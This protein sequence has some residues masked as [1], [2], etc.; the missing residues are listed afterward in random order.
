MGC[1]TDVGTL[2]PSYD[3]FCPS[4]LEPFFKKYMKVFVEITLGA[5][6]SSEGNEVV[7]FLAHFNEGLD[8]ICSKV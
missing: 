7:L 1:Y 5:K 4:K 3:V 6:H 2:Y 8:L